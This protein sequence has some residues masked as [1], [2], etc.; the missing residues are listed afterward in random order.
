MR[1]TVFPVFV[2]MVALTS[3]CSDSDSEVPDTEEGGQAIVSKTLFEVK[4]YDEEH[5][6]DATDC[7]IYRNLIVREN[8]TKLS[9]VLENKADGF[10]DIGVNPDQQWYRLTRT[11]PDSCGTVTYQGK[12]GSTALTIED[13]RNRRCTTPEKTTFVVSEGGDKWFGGT[14]PPN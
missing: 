6:P 13:N 7:T 1:S 14:A 3:A 10:C 11:A 4:L 5:A 9:A 12:Q 2:A 8:G